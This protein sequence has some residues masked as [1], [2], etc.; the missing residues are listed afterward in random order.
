V[1][2]FGHDLS[3]R[4]M[5]AASKLVD[6]NASIDA[7][8]FLEVPPQ[9]SLDAGLE[10]EE[11]AALERLEAARLRARD[12]KLKIRTAV[13]RTRNVGAGIV[14]E[15]KRRNAEVIYLDF[16]GVPKKG[17]SSVASYVLEKR[18][19]RVVIETMGGGAPAYASNGAA[20]SPDR[21]RARVVR[22]GVGPG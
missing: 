19:C 15:A 2:I 5:H 13:V 21:N 7:I 17:L 9:L 3:G 16:A 8:V 10:P 12:E 4:A 11:D 1:P 20:R 14:E 18:P 22:A 6:A